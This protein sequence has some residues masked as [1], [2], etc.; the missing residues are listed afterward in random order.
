MRRQTLRMQSVQTPIIPVVGELIRENP[1]VISLGQGVV[2]YGP[3]PEV[4][5]QIKTFLA[6]PNNHKYALVQGIPALL[7]QIKIKLV[8]ENGISVNSDSAVMVTAGSNM[9][10]MNA[11]LTITEPGDEIIL[12]T[13]Y[14]FNHEMAIAIADCNAVS[15]LT[16][17]NYQLQ[18][19]AI[20]AAVTPKTKAV[21]TISPNNP[22]GA[23][24]TEE[25]LRAVNKF[26]RERG[27]YHIHDQAY[28]YF[29]YGGVKSFSPGSIEGSAKYTI[30]LFSLSK[31][32][33]FASWRIGYM[34]APDHLYESLRK[35]QDTNLICP[36]AISQ[37]A[38][39]GALEAG[40]D[41]CM[42]YVEEL[43]EVRKMTL[44]KLNHLRNFVTVPTPYGAFYCLLRVKT[45]LNAM[46]IVERLI[47]EYK[48]A[49]IPGFTFGLEEGCSLR[50]AYGAMEKH[51]VL[52]GMDRLVSGLRDICAGS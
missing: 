44:E 35:V 28:E 5:N 40:R 6:D 18:L 19:D 13:P 1:G 45:D 21:V 14:Y 29:T 2:N 7:E 51:T 31:A 15:V 41:Y 25:S 4:V 27:L 52:D 34:V 42:P 48:V 47:R 22:T 26:C 10:F 8:A 37:W 39:V 33:G 43:G 12:Q 32:Y 17:D 23:V 20:E 49:V 24:Y 30:S 11:I 38:A 9:A 3:P 50:V 36:P 46:T 16:D